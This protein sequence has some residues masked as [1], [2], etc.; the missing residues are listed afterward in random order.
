MSAVAGRAPVVC[1]V[2]P[3]TLTVRCFEV[4]MAAIYMVRNVTLSL[5]LYIAY[6][7]DNCENN[8][9]KNVIG[10]VARNLPKP[11]HVHPPPP[12]PGS[13]AAAISVYRRSVKEALSSEGTN[14]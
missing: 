6:L 8:Q 14:L 5:F 2:R 1:F 7:E 9:H 11:R 3:L 4:K 13:D 10:H 12:T